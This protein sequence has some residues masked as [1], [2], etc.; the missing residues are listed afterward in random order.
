MRLRVNIPTILDQLFDNSKMTLTGRNSKCF[1]LMLRIR[2][3]FK[4]QGG[5]VFM[6]AQQRTGQWAMSV[7]VSVIHI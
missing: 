2:P 1:G 3:F 4:E 7:T 5:N 6:I